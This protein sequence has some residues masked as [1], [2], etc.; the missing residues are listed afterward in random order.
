MTT[1][2]TPLTLLLILCTLAPLPARDTPA[3]GPDD[4]VEIRGHIIGR[5]GPMGLIIRLLPPEPPIVIPGGHVGI[6][7]VPR[8]DPW[9]R[10]LHSRD[11]ILILGVPHARDLA[12]NRLVT[13]HAWQPP[14]HTDRPT[15]ID[16]QPHATYQWL[17]KD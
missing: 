6:D 5:H 16:G 12:D 15:Q 8:P 13:L 10:P 2:R 3:P 4:I 17:P 11:P 7:I 9:P 14:Q 1:H